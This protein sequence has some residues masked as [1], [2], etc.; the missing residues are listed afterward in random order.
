MRF[1]VVMPSYLGH[2][3]RAASNRP[4]KL[5]RAIESVTKQTF[6]DWELIVV[7]DGCD[8]TVNIVKSNF[9]DNGEIRLFKIDKQHNFSGTPRNVGIRESVG[10]YILYL[11]SDD[12]FLEN[13]LEIIARNLE[14]YDWVWFNNLSYNKNTGN[15]D[16]F[17]ADIKIK[18]RCGTANICHHRRIGVNWSP[19]GGYAKDDWV[20]INTLRSTSANFLKIETPQYGIMHVPTL[21]DY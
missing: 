8:Q 2:Y 15:F 5:V 4:E 3:K 17:H 19:I 16:E 18:G 14:D 12:M 10:D 1:T 6:S 11:D 21:L 13:H 9:L 20:M 7:A